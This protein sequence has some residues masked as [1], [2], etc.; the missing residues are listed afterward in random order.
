MKRYTKFHHAKFHRVLSIACATICAVPAFAQNTAQV[1]NSADLTISTAP[2]QVEIVLHCAFQSE[3]F[4]AETCSDTTF[5]FDLNGRAGG[6]AES[7]MVVQ[8]ELTSEI[9]DTDLLGVRTGSALSLSGGSFEARHLLT[10]AEDGAARYT[11][12]YADGPMTISYLGDC[13]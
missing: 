1:P 10:I 5:S 2:V 6:L 4:E 13:S 7:D 12:H 8:T 11:L 3:C 9:G